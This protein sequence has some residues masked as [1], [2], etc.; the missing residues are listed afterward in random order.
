MFPLIRGRGKA[1]ERKIDLIRQGGAGET[2]HTMGNHETPHR[3]S[4]GQEKLGCVHPRS[5]CKMMCVSGDN[6]EKGEGKG[7]GRNARICR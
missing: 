7:M 3:I 6:Q 2:K 4:T 5:I 1:I